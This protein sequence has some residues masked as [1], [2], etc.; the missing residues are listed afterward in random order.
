MG[1]IVIYLFASE[2]D[3]S[4][5]NTRKAIY[6]KEVFNGPDF[7]EIVYSPLPDPKYRYRGFYDGKDWVTHLEALEK[8]GTIKT[9]DGFFDPI[10][11]KYF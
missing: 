1:R 8:L 5:G 9:Q 10:T 11:G 7:K 6:L 4:C 2:S 3:R